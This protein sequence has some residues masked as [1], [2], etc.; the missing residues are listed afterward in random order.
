[1]APVDL[2]AARLRSTLRGDKRRVERSAGCHPVSARGPGASST[3]RIPGSTMLLEDGPV[4]LAAA[5][6]R[7]T[8]RGDNRRV[9][10]S[11][12]RHPV[13]ARGPGASSTARIPGSTMLLEDGPVDLAAARLRSTLRGAVGWNVAQ[14]VI[15]FSPDA[16]GA[17]STARIPDTRRRVEMALVDLAAARLGSTLRGDNRSVE[18]SAGVIRFSRDAP[19]ASS[20]ARIPDTR[21]HVEMAPVDLAAARLRSTL[22]GDNRR[23]ERSA[24]VIRFSRDAPG[25][26]STARIPDTRRHVEMAP[27]D[28]AA[29]RLRST[30]R[31][32]NRRVERSA[33][34][35]RFSRDAPGASSTARIPDPRRRMETASALTPRPAP[36]R[37]CCAPLPCRCRRRSP[38]AR[39]RSRPRCRGTA[40]CRP[41]A[42]GSGIRDRS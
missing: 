3:A 5:R 41:G 10:R 18:R 21:R 11:A 34:V 42:R 32:D 22:R 9:E 35:I 1:M 7:S 19:G 20:T 31:G 27:V 29:A 12:G 37:S 33:G 25:A 24:G 13:S 26:S 36:R 23:V 2:A 30:L 4:D 15:R 39:A 14:E 8:L 17:S 40:R 6:L 38:R 28:L 16:P